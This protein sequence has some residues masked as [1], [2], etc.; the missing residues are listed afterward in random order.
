[1]AS[2]RDVHP[3]LLLV[4]KGTV[5]ADNLP[6]TGLQLRELTIMRQSC[7]QFYRPML[8][9][10]LLCW[11]APFLDRHRGGH[12]AS[13]KCSTLT[14]GF[15]EQAKRPSNQRPSNPRVPK[16]TATQLPGL[17]GATQFL[18]GFLWV[19]TEP[20]VFAAVCLC[21]CVFW[22]GS[23]VAWRL[24]CGEREGKAEAE[25][26]GSNSHDPL[27]FQGRGPWLPPAPPPKSAPRPG[28]RGKN[29]PS[30]LGG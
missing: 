30:Q 15:L 7:V 14:S 17:H 12:F 6:G 18:R 10:L 20:R 19:K 4:D 26:E 11:P 21:V 25:R 16:K 3:A 9:V 5:R 1:M 24:L 29:G 27:K 2:L 13:E 8:L 23:D 22:R 28:L